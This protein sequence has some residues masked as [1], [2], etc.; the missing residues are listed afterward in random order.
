MKSPQLDPDLCRQR[1]KRLLEAT[2]SMDADLLVLSKP[3]SIQWATGWRAAP[4]YSPI[5]AIDREAKAILAM[6]AHEVDAIAAVDIRIAYE[7]TRLCTV[8][9]EQRQLASHALAEALPAPARMGCEFSAIGGYLLST[10]SAKW[11]DLEPIVH[12]LR[13]RKGRDE[14]MMIE[15]ANSAN[16]ALYAAAREIIRPGVRELDVFGALLELAIH[17]LG[18][19]PTYFGQDFQ[20]NS[21]GG[22]PRN[23]IVEKGELYILDL[24]VGYRGYHSDNART[25]AV[26]GYPSNEQQCAWHTVAQVFE[27]IEESVR[28]GVSCRRIFEEVHT[29]LGQSAPCV[30]DHHLG[31]G[32]GL[33]PHESPHINPCWDDY[34]EEGD[35]IAVEPGLYDRTLRAG[36]RLEQNY[37]VGAGSVELVSD[38]P[39]EL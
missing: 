19:P 23:R 29:F 26:G 35:L 20:C 8:I 27:L 6:P 34:F 3:E 32:L 33:A 36:V 2:A 9:D 18:E 31:H 10:W 1:Q 21:R 16:R 22:P 25:F 12:R 17:E 4:C 24:G 7:A 39:L 11:I 28:P 14:L 38:W 37:R 13:R 5:L 15:K 30:F